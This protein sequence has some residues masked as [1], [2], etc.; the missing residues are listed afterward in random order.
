MTPLHK[1]DATAKLKRFLDR[2]TMPRALEGK[3]QAI[4]D[5]IDGMVNIIVRHA[6]SPF[7]EWWQRVEEQLAEKSETRAWPTTGE[8]SSVCRALSPKTAE[9]AETGSIDSDAVWAERIKSGEGCSEPHAWGRDG[10]RLIRKRLIGEDDLTPWRSR[11][12]FKRQETYGDAEA[13]SWEQE[14]KAAWPVLMAE[15]QSEPKQ[16]NMPKLGNRM[17][18]AE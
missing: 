9:V 17:E 13:R 10:V 8:L 6:R 7:A 5:E 11:F 12:F 14:R 4:A 15:K 2:R 16:R 1:A 3:P 18:A